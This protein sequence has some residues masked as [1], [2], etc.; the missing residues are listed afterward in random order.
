MTKSVL[1]VYG[2]RPEA[3]KMA[4]V[5]DALRSSTKLRPIVA[6]TGQHRAMLDQVNNLFGIEPAHDLDIITTRQTLES[7]TI[8]ALTGVSEVIAAEHPDAVLV[9]G[10]T[11]TAFASA[12][13]AFYQQVPVVHLEAGLRT[14]NRYNPFPEEMNRLLATQLASLH[15][16]P[17]STSRDEPAE[18]RRGSRGDCRDR[19]HRDRRPARRGLLARSRSRT[20]SCARP[21]TPLQA[22]SCWSRLTDANRGANRC[23]RRPERWPRSPAG[24]PIS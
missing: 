20:R 7:V 2:T 3:I 19:Q 10:D 21:W 13:A 22:T 1:V 6:V 16:A 15:L 17:T 23:G 18:E 4:P 24:I 12:L 9:Q 14:N 5:V 11:T 8:K